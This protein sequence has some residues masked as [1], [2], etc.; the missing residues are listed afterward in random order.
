[1]RELTWRRLAMVMPALFLAIGCE[2]DS[3]RHRRPS[4]EAPVASARADESVMPRGENVKPLEI[5]AKKSFYRN[6]PEPEELL[7]GVLR[8]AVVREGPNTRDMPFKLI[9]GDGEFSVYTS[10]IDEERLRPYV[11]REVEIVGKRID[12]RDE[13]YGIEIWIA[14]ISMR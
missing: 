6:R 14:T 13:G 4:I 3:E 7:T 2:Q 1:M 12:Q 11:D 5:F 8:T 9:I 10:G